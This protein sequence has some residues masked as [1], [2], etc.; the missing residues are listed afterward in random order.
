MKGIIAPNIF[1]V[2]TIESV[3]KRTRQ[4]RLGPEQMEDVSRWIDSYR[5][6][7]HRRLDRLETIIERRKGERT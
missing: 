7:W 5:V 2:K 1:L 6:Q 4:C 3:G